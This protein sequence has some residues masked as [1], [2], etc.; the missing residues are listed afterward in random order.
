[1]L[2]V[3]QHVEQ[4]DSF[5]SYDHIELLR[6]YFS[7]DVAFVTLPDLLDPQQLEVLVSL[8]RHQE[9]QLRAADREHSLVIKPFAIC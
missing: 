8:R 4:R 7:P 5:P 6:V 3:A 2:E 9:S 1:M